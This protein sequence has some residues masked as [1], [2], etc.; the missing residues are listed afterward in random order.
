MGS[1]RNTRQLAEAAGPSTGFI[2][3]ADLSDL[4]LGP[5]WDFLRLGPFRY[6]MLIRTGVKARM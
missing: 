6:K 5:G 2:L 1:E 3:P 4:T